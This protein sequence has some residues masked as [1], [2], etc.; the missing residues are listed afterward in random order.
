LIGELGR[1]IFKVIIERCVSII[2][3]SLLEFLVIFRIP[4]TI[5][6]LVF[7]LE[8]LSSA[9]SSLYCFNIFCSI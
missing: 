6:S 3:I 7:F 5:A 4:L 9:Y 8:S 1:L 2:V